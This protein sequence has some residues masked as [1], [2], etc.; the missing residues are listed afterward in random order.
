MF[1]L[2]GIKTD[3]SGFVL[4]DMKSL[5]I[6]ATSVPGIHMCGAVHMPKDIPDSVAQGSAAA[7]LAAL[8]ISIP[9]GE[10]TEALTEEDLELIAA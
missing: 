2:L 3:E 9:Q 5:M 10:E 8:D 1:E 6:S 7:A 4:P